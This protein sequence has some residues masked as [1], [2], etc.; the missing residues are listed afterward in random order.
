MPGSQDALLVKLQSQVLG[1]VVTSFGEYSGRVRVSRPL[2]NRRQPF[3]EA[4]SGVDVNR[5][6]NCGAVTHRGRMLRV[7]S[8]ILLDLVGGVALLLWGLHMVHSGIVRAFGAD[9][10]RFL[11]S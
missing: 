9:L 4:E 10:R 3:T 2:F 6:C 8:M 1:N 11:G 5:P 7:G